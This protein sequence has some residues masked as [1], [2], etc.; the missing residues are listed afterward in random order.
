VNTLLPILV[1]IFAIGFDVLCLIDLLRADEVRSLPPLAWAVVI[2]CFT[3][4]GGIAYLIAGRPA[5]PGGGG[6]A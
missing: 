6:L 2:C 4:L 1:A 5:R 3:P